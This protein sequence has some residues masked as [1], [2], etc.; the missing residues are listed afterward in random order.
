MQ[1]VR[2]LLTTLV[3]NKPKGNYS[4]HVL[5]GKLVF[6][7]GHIPQT[8]E[9]ILTGQLQT[10]SLQ[11]G[12]ERCELACK[13]LLQTLEDNYKLENIKRIV[14]LTVFINCDHTFTKHSL[15]ADAASNLLIKTF[16]KSSMHARS[17]VG[18]SSLPFG[19]S[20]ELELVAEI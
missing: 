10:I 15:I 4:S 8:L 17:A 7:S 11:E 18:C 1:E 2:K 19:A 6:L 5:C 14:K 3:P 20:L 12:Q 9:G 16:G 13:Y